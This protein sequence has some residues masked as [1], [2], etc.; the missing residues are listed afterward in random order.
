MFGRL[1]AVSRQHRHPVDSQHSNEENKVLSRLPIATFVS[2][3][4]IA[5]VPVPSLKGYLDELTKEIKPLVSR[6]LKEYSD[7]DINSVNPEQEQA[8]SNLLSE[9]K[10]G[11]HNLQLKTTDEYL[12]PFF[13][14]SERIIEYLEKEVEGKDDTPTHFSSHVGI[15]ESV[16]QDVK[17]YSFNWYQRSPQS[18][19]REEGNAKI[20]QELDAEADTYLKGLAGYLP[21]IKTALSLGSSHDKQR[22]SRPAVSDQAS[23]ESNTPLVPFPAV[24]FHASTDMAM[25]L[26]TLPRSRSAKETQSIKKIQDLVAQVNQSYTEDRDVK[27]SSIGD[28]ISQIIDMF[29]ELETLDKDNLQQFSRSRNMFDYLAQVV[30][31]KQITPSRSRAHVNDLSETCVE[32]RETFLTRIRQGI[33]ELN[34][35]MKHDTLGLQKVALNFQ[36]V[37]TSPDV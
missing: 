4:E 29:S 15:F 10:N 34:R 37:S 25:S 30:E 20:I 8:I 13:E 18:D 12:K 1:P 14:R 21:E 32:A 2:N 27:D 26:H 6:V 23:V 24:A 17:A 11:F 16:L 9:I 3:L 28:K 7:T 36:S 5:C 35:P 22:F 33:S 19:R 31:D